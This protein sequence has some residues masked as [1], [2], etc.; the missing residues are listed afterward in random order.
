MQ[1]GLLQSI[2]PSGVY[3][4]LQK[5][6][7]NKAVTLPKWCTVVESNH[8]HFSQLHSGALVYATKPFPVAK[9]ADLCQQRLLKQTKLIFGRW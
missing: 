1:K 5:H 4:N 8:R 6:C 7:M 3:M 9:L 2:T